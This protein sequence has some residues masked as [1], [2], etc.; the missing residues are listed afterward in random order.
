MIILILSSGS[1]T[2]HIYN[3]KKKK[4]TLFI[5]TLGFISNG[6]T[7]YST[8]FFQTNIFLA[9]EKYVGIHCGLCRPLFTFN[10]HDPSPQLQQLT[11]HHSPWSPLFKASTS[12]CF[13]ISAEGGKTIMKKATISFNIIVLLSHSSSHTMTSLKLHQKSLI[14]HPP[15]NT[16]EF[17]HTMGHKSQCSTHRHAQ[18]P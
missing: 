2:W 17:P 16:G 8:T 10:L 18:K 11:V 15:N 12:T 4:F 13:S 9:V 3:N 7:E 6:N 5:E 1:K 14:F